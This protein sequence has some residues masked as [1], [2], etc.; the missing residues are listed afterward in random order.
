M[1]SNALGLNI[2]QKVPHLL[3]AKNAMRVIIYLI[4]VIVVRKNLIVFMEIKTLEYAHNV[5][6]SIILISKMGNASPIMKIMTLNIAQKLMENA[7]NVL[8]GLI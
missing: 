1:L 3:N 7:I 8:K 4:M 5:K 6:G 2:V